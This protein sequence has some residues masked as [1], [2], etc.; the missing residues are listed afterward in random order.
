M[1]FP[2]KKETT[3]QLSHK[4]VLV[5]T[6]TTHGLTKDVTVPRGEF[7]E[8]QN[9]AHDVTKETAWKREM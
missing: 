6:R 7:R 8:R 4:W 2:R 3:I 1:Y 5:V 9:L